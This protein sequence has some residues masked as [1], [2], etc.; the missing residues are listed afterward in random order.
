MPSL[1]LIACTVSM[2][3]AACSL[4]PRYHRP[5]IAP[6]PAWVTASDADAQQ[7]PPR[8]WWR[9]FNSAD[10]DSFIAQARSANDDLRA[11][12]ARLHQADAQRRIARA[13]PSPPW[14][15]YDRRQFQPASVR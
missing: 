13:R 5:D 12:L 6:P 15:L 10:L 14:R 1:R 2:L 7:W 11:A 3:L 4:G 9:G 8:D